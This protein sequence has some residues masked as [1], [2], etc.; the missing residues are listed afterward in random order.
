MGIRIFAEERKISGDGCGKT[1]RLSG[2]D[3]KKKKNN[4]NK[5]FRYLNGAIL[6]GH[7]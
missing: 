1:F 5:L 3:T 7:T 4:K 6:A 2:H